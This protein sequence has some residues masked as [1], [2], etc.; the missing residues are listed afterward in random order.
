MGLYPNP[1]PNP[2][3][4]PKANSNQDYDRELNPDIGLYHYHERP[5]LFSIDPTGGPTLRGYALTMR[6]ISFAGLRTVAGV[7]PLLSPS[8]LT[9]TLP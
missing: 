6:G 2:N 1:N 4:N 9:L 8:T 3:P 7:T 5:T